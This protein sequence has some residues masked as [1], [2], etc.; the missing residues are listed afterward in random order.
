MFC[1]LP[2]HTLP[3]GAKLASSIYDERQTKLLAAGIEITEQLLDTLARRNVA[4][5]VVGEQDLARVLAFK[6]QG[7]ARTA[8]PD[9]PGL[10]LDPPSDI[11]RALDARSATIHPRHLAP[12]VHAYSKRLRPTPHAGYDRDCLNFLADQREYHVGRV[13]E[14]ATACAQGDS[15]RIPQA[16]EV[17]Q[18]SLKAAAHDFDAYACLGAHPS[19]TPYPTRH[20][21]HTAMIAAAV[22]T[23]LG[24]DEPALV[25]L[26]FG[27]LLHD[28]GMLTVDRMTFDARKVLDAEDFSAIAVHPFRTIELLARNLHLVPLAAQLVVFQLHERANGTGYPRGRTLTETHPLARI[29]AVADA[30]TAMV[31]SR[32]H[33]RGMMPYFA[34]EKL[35]KDVAVGRFDPLAVRGLLQAIGLFPVGS[36]VELREG[37]V[38]RVIRTNAADYTRP[39]IELWRN[40]R[41][42]GR[43]SIVDLSHEPALTIVRPLTTLE[44]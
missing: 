32:P 34:M 26:G 38:G 12:S 28:I 9:R 11:C 25:E 41:P 31:T 16:C 36:Y 42:H 15:S 2:L 3:I 10:R 21:L 29:A 13:G 30:Y 22:G 4:S 14:V 43:P 6:P 39:M 23:A 27:C 33:R 24:L 5:V 8:A 7:R 44:R 35:V 18:E 19:A 37:Y 17:F 20:S 1:S 40:A